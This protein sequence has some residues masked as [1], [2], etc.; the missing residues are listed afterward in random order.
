VEEKTLNK[1]QLEA[2]THGSGP[3]LI[4]AGAGTGKTTVI[5][6]RVKWLISTGHAQPSEI[7]CLT[8]TEKAAAEMQERIDVALPYGY[9]QMWVSTFHSFCD[10]VLRDEGLHLGLDTNYKL[11]ADSD[12]VSL[13]KRH[14]FDFDLN[15]Y[16]PLGNPTKFL[17]AALQHFNRLQDEDVSPSQYLTW[18]KDQDP[19][20]QELA[21]FY[22]DYSDLKIKDGVLNFSDLISFTLKLFR[23]RPGVLTLYQQ[24]FKYILVDEFQDTNYAQNELVNLLA[25]P[26]RNLTVVA[27]DD[28]A[29]YRWRGAAISNVIQFRSTY[30]DAILITLSQNYRSTQEILDKAYTLI[31]NNN[32]D[33]LEIKEKI[34][35]KLISVRK[36][37]G[38]KIE[39]LHS[40]Q[41]ESEADAVSKKIKE[42]LS[43][44]ER[45]NQLTYKDIAIL[46]RAN[47]HAEPFVRALSRHGIPHQF[48]GP[49]RLLHQPEIKDLIAYLKVLYNFEDNVSFYRVLAMDLFAIPARDLAVITNLARKQNLSLFAASE[50]SDLLSVKPLVS[51]I[52]RHLHLVPKENTGQILYDFLEKSGLL[53]AILDYRIPVDE[54]KAQ[55]IMKFFNKLKSFE[56]QN[57]EASVHAVVDWLNLS[58]DMGES[59]LAA[60]IDW[61]TNDAVNILTVHSAKGLEF[62]VVFLINLVVDRFPSRSRSELIPVPDALIKEIL[63]EGDSHLQEERRLFYVGMTRA[64][65]HLFFTASDYYGE[66]K[67]I[68]RL[69]PFV[70]E[71][72]GQPKPSSHTTIQPS[73][74]DWQIPPVIINDKPSSQVTINYLSYSQIQT[75]LDCPLHYKAKYI[76]KIPTPPSAASSFGNSIHATLKDFYTHPHLNILD[77]LKK[78]WTSEGFL[79][80][81]HE[82][83]YFKKGEKYLTEYIDK[84]FDPKQLP[85]KLE[86]PFTVPLTKSLKIGGKIDRV[87][88]LPDGSIEIIDYKTSS[89][90]LT[91]KEADSDLQLSFY[92]LAATLLP[93][94]PFNKK[95]SQVKLSLYY[96]EDQSKVTTS[97]ISFQ[98]DDAKK[99][100]TDY[101][102]QINR[103]DFKCSRSQLCRICDYK[104]LCDFAV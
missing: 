13:L 99:Q 95:P 9:T 92:A 45:S 54:T 47:S 98:L 91:Q 5:T 90:S 1:Q 28:Q 102:D 64:R 60:E 82:H 63:P 10:H 103:S 21:R 42:L 104:M 25:N 20:F 100:I 94:S 81:K 72:L 40:D 65:D 73:L 44:N 38:D 101:A 88:L 83:E 93:M 16:R 84:N 36:V 23:D 34:D 19:N 31:Q 96:F 70:I 49:G 66:A 74:L 79:N 4:I 43:N 24:K 26:T 51:L 85:I 7:L 62:P 30:P 75:F 80:K 71:T 78:N 59:P 27:D 22:N 39:L 37:K 33:R 87:D 8:F 50:Q 76:L 97:R 57:S 69:S 52:D 12:A 58:S 61:S 2:V 29:I 55:N 53:K 67:R 56:T 86:E 15:Y 35:K 18:S 41:V 77:L 68:K 46:V 11:L 32:P 89:K 48:L 14:L 3:L 6:E 17:A